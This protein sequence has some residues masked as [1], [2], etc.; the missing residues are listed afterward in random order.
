MSATITVMCMYVY[1]CKDNDSASPAH[2]REILT[3]YIILFIIIY[4][5]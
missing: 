5:I 1:V 2:K 3:E 4:Y